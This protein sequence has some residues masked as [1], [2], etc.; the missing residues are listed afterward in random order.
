MIDLCVFIDS[1]FFISELS[2]PNRRGRNLD[3]PEDHPKQG[4]RYKIEWEPTHMQPTGHLRKK[5]NAMIN[6]VAKMHTIFPLNV[7]WPK[8][9]SQSFRQAFEYIEVCFF[10]FSDLD[11]F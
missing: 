5:F 7:N 9:T 10:L 11:F 4:E 1:L 8:Q 2:L 6:R 3:H